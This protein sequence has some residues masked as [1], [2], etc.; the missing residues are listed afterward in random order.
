VTKNVPHYVF[1]DG[2]NGESGV[3]KLQITVTP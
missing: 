2:M 3:A 1:V